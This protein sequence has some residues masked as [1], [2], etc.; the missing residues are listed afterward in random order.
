[1]TYE[2]NE[3][4]TYLND[5]IMLIVLLCLQAALL[6]E[7]GRFSTKHFFFLGALKLIKEVIAKISRK[8]LFSLLFSGEITQ[9]NKST[10][11]KVKKTFD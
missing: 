8:Q 4:N 6:L 7:E 3:Q 1:M 9:H 11:F 2:W 10:G 5:L